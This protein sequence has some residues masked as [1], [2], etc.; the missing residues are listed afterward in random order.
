MTIPSKN[1]R[2]QK[3][4]EEENEGTAEGGKKTSLRV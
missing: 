3:E 4:E 1:P 2:S